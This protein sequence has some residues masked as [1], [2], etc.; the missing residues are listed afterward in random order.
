MASTWLGDHHEI[1]SAPT[2]SIH[3]LQMAR[4]QGIITI[5][6]GNVNVV[7]PWTQE[8]KTAHGYIEAKHAAYKLA[9]VKIVRHCALA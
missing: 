6:N 1:P 2:N 9:P 5:S 7:M 8:T 3:E 4:Y